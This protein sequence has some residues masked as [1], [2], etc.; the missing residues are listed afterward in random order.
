MHL[1][2]FDEKLMDSVVNVEELVSHFKKVIASSKSL[3]VPPR[4]TASTTSSW[5]AAMVAVGEGF[6]AVKIV[7]VYYSNP[8]R[9]LPLVRGLALL[10]D[11]ETGEVVLAADASPLTGWRT[12]AATAVALEVLRATEGV[13]GII[14]AGVQ[15]R[16]HGRL[17]T[18]LYNYERV[19]VYSRS[20]E[21]ASR[22]AAEIGGER[23]SSL[24]SLL[25]NSN[26]I[27]AATD[28]RRPVVKGSLLRPGTIVASIGAPKPVQELDAVTVERARCVLADTRRGVLEESGDIPGTGVKIVELGE[29]LRG[30]DCDHGDVAVYKSVGTALLDYAMLTYLY[31]RS[32]RGFQGQQQAAPR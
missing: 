27:V 16:Y 22:L 23:A 31:S 3:A 14:G 17:L 7:G 6:Q 15:A 21:K 24:E 11:E 28:S 12:A 8:S 18:R 2:V 1:T 29:A 20:P 30:E 32:R 19:L 25:S 4:L 9:G 26:V 5:L 10:F 13:L